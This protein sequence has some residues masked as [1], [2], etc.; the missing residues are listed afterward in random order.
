MKLL[1]IIRDDDFGFGFKDPLEYKERRAARVIVF[2]KDN[3]IALLHATRDNYHKLPGGGVEEG[4]DIMSALRREV[5]EEIGCEITNT[6]ELGVVEEFRNQ[7]SF[8]QIS[9]CFI[10]ELSGEKGKPKLTQ[11]EIDEGFEPIW[12]SLDEAIK[13]IDSEDMKKFYRAQF[14]IARDLVFLK[15]A[16][17]YLKEYGKKSS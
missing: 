13:I 14:M 11:S 12:L 7:H 8:H 16:K 6:K 1:K 2:D 5:I 17:N 15:E 4:E 3:N 10:A 9:N